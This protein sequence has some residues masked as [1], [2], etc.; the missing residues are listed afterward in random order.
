MGWCRK[1]WILCSTICYSP[2]I[3]K[4]EHACGWP[5]LLL[6]YYS[7]FL[8]PYYVDRRM[9]VWAGSKRATHKCNALAGIL[10]C[11]KYEEVILC[12]W[13][14]SY[15]FGRAWCF[16]LCVR[17]AAEQ[18]LHTLCIP[19]MGTSQELGVALGLLPQLSPLFW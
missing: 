17:Y 11:T 2:F 18:S 15:I 6:V 4:E 14:G 16:S 9:H 1:V 8:H 19:W 7:D 13:A 12:F 10:Q 5:A 3:K